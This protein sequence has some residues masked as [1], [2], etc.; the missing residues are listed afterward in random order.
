MQFSQETQLVMNEAQKIAS[1]TGGLIY[2]EQLLF[3]L[4]SVPNTKAYEILRALDI[5][6]ELIARG[7]PKYGVKQKVGV[8]VRAR[9]ILDAAMYQ[10]EKDNNGITT[11]EHILYAICLDMDAGARRIIVENGGNPK[12]II[13]Q[14]TGLF[15]GAT[16]TNSI[17]DNNPN[18]KIVAF[19]IDD[20]SMPEML[21]K[22][23]NMN[24]DGLNTDDIFK[25]Y[26]MSRR[27]PRQQRPDIER[28]ENDL[29]N[30]DEGNSDEEQ[31]TPFTQYPNFRAERRRNANGKKS[32]FD[33]IGTDLVQLAKEGKLDPV[34]GRDKE[35]ER[36]IEILCRRTKNNPV[37]LG[38]PG[39]GKTAIVEGLANAIANEKVPDVL[40]GKTILSLDIAGMVAGTKYRGEFE[41]KLK[42]A[43]DQIQKD[44]NVI[45]FIDEIHMITKAGDTSDGAM[46][47]GN[48]LK[49]ILSRGAMQTIGATTISEYRKFIEKDEALERRFQPIYLDQPSVYDTIE[50]LKGLREKYSDYHQVEIT[51]EAIEAAAILS[52]RYISDRFLPDKA[53]DLIDEA[54]AKKR[55]FNFVVPTTI[56]DLETKIK[57]Y[58]V[59]INDAVRHEI[60]DEADALKKE[61]DNLIEQK[62]KEF[63]KWEEEKKNVKLSIG[64]QEIAE[65][66]ASITNIPVSKITQTEGE[67]VANLE[68][69]L[70]QRVIG[71]DEAVE[72]IA[73]AIKRSRA[74][75]QNP[76]RPIGSFILLG[77][78]GVGKTELS[79]ALAEA[80]FGDE[81]ALIRVD[82]SEYMDQTSVT[83]LIGSDP[84]YVGYDDGG[85]LT[86]KVRR[87]PYS[88]VL[89][90]EIE[91]AHPDIF[92]V[93][94][95]VLDDGR[96]TDSHGRLVNFKNTVILMTSNIGAT[97]IG[98]S[99]IGFGAKSS[100]VDY[101][102]MK[103]T[104]MKALRKT[105]KPEFL[106][107][108][109]DILIFHK[110]SKESVAK[111]AGIMLENLTKRLKEQGIAIEV[112]DKAVE[113]IVSQGYNE[114]YGA[115]PLRRTIQ[116]MVE[117][118]LSDMILRGLVDRREIIVVDSDGTQLTF[119]KK[120]K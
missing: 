61:R 86:E 94:L 107:R 50:I 10:A 113:Y 8:A 60:Y 44:K 27:R 56:R 80:L 119:K 42:N 29:D 98:K 81:N 47:M 57:D 11:P 43:I 105:M 99:Q 37:I 51:D 102:M 28:I 1:S 79:K 74:G 36:V 54:A 22:F 100:I 68:N 46:S 7:L 38:E 15:S 72:T 93:L 40:R 52:D 53:I 76:K 41:E 87:K 75:L 23:I 114:E 73:R 6:P 31:Q 89:F 59:K 67:K 26:M 110:L 5:T 66:V 25:Q 65:L 104:Q 62:E 2:S 117:D 35:I 69:V 103:E 63:L 83:K 106:N 9:N 115:R 85:Q 90:D 34:I 33:E 88:V 71:Q 4:T 39:V 19:N 120:I 49:P 112:T 78:T 18:S 118:V 70:K 21:A 16:P 30:R 3:G 92:N 101:E 91:K 20:L 55:I 95:Q 109:D 48:I 12:I 14:L 77:P 108:V 82:M 97:E 84:G 13:Q 17:F 111:I 45:V 96:L 58:E 32:K 24:L 64:E 116:R